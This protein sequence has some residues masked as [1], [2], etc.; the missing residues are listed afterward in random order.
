MISKSSQFYP[1]SRVSLISLVTP[2]LTSESVSRG[3]QTKTN[4]RLP[5]LTQRKLPQKLGKGS[6]P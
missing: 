1:V 5:F 6:Y 3:A 2:K 4:G